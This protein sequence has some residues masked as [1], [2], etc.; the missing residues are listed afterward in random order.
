MLSRYIVKRMQGKT[1]YV[2]W[3]T[4]ANVMRSTDLGFDDALDLADQLNAGK[5]D[6]IAMPA[7]SEPQQVPQQQQQ[8][9]PN[10]E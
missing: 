3:D 1:R 6:A 10:K 4:T 7:P 5:P 9:Q 2:V 8:P